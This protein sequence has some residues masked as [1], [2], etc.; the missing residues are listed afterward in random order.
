M[1]ILF[2]FEELSS[3][4]SRHIPMRSHAHLIMAM[5]RLTY[6]LFTLLE[7]EQFSL[8]VEELAA[9]AA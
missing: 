6:E 5:T 7:Y 2:L 1:V 8:S 9:S 4:R 3:R